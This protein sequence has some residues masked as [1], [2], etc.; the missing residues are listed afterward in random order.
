MPE[1]DSIFKLARALE[2]AC[3]HR[4]IDALWLRGG[5][6]AGRFRGSRARRRPEQPLA[7]SLLDQRVACGIGNVYK[8]EVLFPAGFDP[9]RSSGS[10]SDTE[11][12]ALYRRAAALVALN[13]AAGSRVTHPGGRGADRHWV[14][15]RSGRPHLRCGRAIAAKRIG[16]AARVTY[17]Y[18]RCQP[19]PK[20]VSTAGAAPAE[21]DA[22]D[23]VAEGDGR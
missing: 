15:R 10:V 3:L 1:G 18:P 19:S 16:N 9:R 20:P 11:L 17:W 12:V 23:A 7:S 21:G 5:G 13:T 8:N 4:A 22:R 14:Y 2:R 6:G